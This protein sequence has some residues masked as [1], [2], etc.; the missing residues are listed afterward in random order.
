MIG[1][2]QHKSWNSNNKTQFVDRLH[3]AN[4]FLGKARQGSETI[5]EWEHVP[6]Y[7]EHLL[8]WV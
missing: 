2:L 5:Q 3:C 8:I 1:T 4:I 7:V 6:E